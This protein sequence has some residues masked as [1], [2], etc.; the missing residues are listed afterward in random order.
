MKALYLDSEFSPPLEREL[1]GETGQEYRME[2]ET[3][4][5]VIS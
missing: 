4:S 1:G 2:T 5:V 3:P